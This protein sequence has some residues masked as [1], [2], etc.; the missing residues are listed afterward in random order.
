MGTEADSA[1]S[2]LDAYDDLR[3][4]LESP[5][6]KIVPN[7]TF[8]DALDKAAAAA[9]A[10]SALSCEERNVCA[11][12]FFFWIIKA[13]GYPEAEKFLHLARRFLLRKNTAAEKADDKKHELLILL[14]FFQ[15]NVKGTASRLVAANKTAAKKGIPVDRRFGPRGSTSKAAMV[16][17]L[18]ELRRRRDKTEG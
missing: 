14:D 2:V 4:I 10:L 11:P 17:Y 12:L 5:A 9:Q 18:K 15:G 6:W 13:I 3:A 8:D 16:A 7:A 1:D